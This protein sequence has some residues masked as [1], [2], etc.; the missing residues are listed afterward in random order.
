MMTIMTITVKMT[1]QR[2]MT[3]KLLAKRRRNGQ[4]FYRVKWVGYKKTTWIPE[5]DIG[6]GL[7]VEF[8]NKFTKDGKSRKRKKTSCFFKLV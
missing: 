5:N 7:L 6:E 8:H 1:L 2:T 4:N 3:E